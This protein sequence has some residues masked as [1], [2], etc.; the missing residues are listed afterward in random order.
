MAE[1]MSLFDERRMKLPE[2]DSDLHDKLHLSSP[3]SFVRDS[4]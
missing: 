3:A 1:G 2:T 4:A